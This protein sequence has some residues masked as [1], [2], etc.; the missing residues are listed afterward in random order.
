MRNTLPRLASN[1]LF[2]GVV[3]MTESTK[4]IWPA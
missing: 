1:D 3:T 4:I 2:D